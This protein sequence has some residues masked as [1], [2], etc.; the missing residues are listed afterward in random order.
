MGEIIKVL[1]SVLSPVVLAIAA[2]SVYWKAFETPNSQQ[3]TFGFA[4]MVATFWV[5]RD[6][7]LTND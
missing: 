1:L 5:T 2:A 3:M 4:I 6:R 7:R